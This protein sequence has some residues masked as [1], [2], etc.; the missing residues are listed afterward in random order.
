ML[1]R[2]RE[3]SAEG[4]SSAQRGW[5]KV[6]QVSVVRRRRFMNVKFYKLSIEK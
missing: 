2:K 1:T 5:A 3:V 4:A 6:A